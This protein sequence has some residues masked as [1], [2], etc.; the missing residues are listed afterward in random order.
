[1]FWDLMAKLTIPLS[2]SF[3]VL[4]F[5]FD[6]YVECN[7]DVCSALDS[8]HSSVFTCCGDFDADSCGTIIHDCAAIS[9]LASFFSV[10]LTSDERNVVRELFKV[11]DLYKS[12]QNQTFNFFFI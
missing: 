4:F 3:I 11:E 1:L 5:L 6:Y 2:L 9:D 10:N 7:S 8:Y 12:T